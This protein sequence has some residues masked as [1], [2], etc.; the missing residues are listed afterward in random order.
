MVAAK[1]KM[2]N[3]VTGSSALSTAENQIHAW[4]RNKNVSDLDDELKM[5]ERRQKA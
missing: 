3:K 1:K 4:N 2:E 5:K